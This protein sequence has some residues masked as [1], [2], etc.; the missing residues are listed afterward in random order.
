IGAGT[1]DLGRPEAEAWRDELFRHHP[2]FPREHLIAET[3]STNTAENIAFTAALLEKRYPNF[4]FGGGLRTAIVVASPSRLRR[5]KLTL[6][7]LQ[8]ALHVI[9]VHRS[10]STFDRERELY[11][12]QGIDYLDH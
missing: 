9:R 4:I 2:N 12:S 3:R 1:G 11:Q 8:P 7:H 5:V 6:Q 10:S